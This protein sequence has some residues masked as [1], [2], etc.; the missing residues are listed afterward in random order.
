MCE[1][2][3]L[4]FAR[5]ISAD[6]SIREFAGRG[7]ENADG[8]G[9]AWYPDR[10]VAVVK[11][12]VRWG[13]T[14]YTTFLENYPALR[15]SLYIA[16]VRRRTIGVEPTYADTHPFARELNG[17]EYCFAHNGTLR[18][19]I[20][21]LPLGRYRPVGVTDSERAFCYLLETIARQAEPLR[22]EED[23]RALHRELTQFNELGQLNCLLSDGERLFCYH[24][25]AGYKGL[26]FRK[27]HL[28]DG[29]TRRFEDEELKI[30]L[31]EGAVNHGF[32]VATN[33][34]SHSGWQRFLPGELIVLEKGI[35]CFSSHRRRDDTGFIVAREH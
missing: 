29:E 20:W 15:S 1:L 25:Q 6:F 34:L 9:L 35:I 28:R 26:T 22:S 14:P 7:T 18:G 23:W 12:P 30:D 11:E 19:R 21:E 27:V 3:G 10:A 5:P 33:P 8:W 13:Q 32:V 24:D 16:H 17:R 2:M 4:S 31:A